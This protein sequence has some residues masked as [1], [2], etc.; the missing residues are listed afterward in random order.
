M[1]FHQNHRQ[2]QQPSSCPSGFFTPAANCTTTLT[3]QQQHLQSIYT[4]SEPPAMYPYACTGSNWNTSYSTFQQGTMAPQ[5]HATSP[6]FIGQGAYSNNHKA[7]NP[8]ANIQG[9]EIPQSEWKCDPCE[10]TFDSKRALDSHV[11]SHINCSICSFSAAPKVVK[12]HH[13]ATHGKFS[14]SGFKSITVAI[15]GCPIQQFRI[16]VGNHPDDIRAWIAERKRRFPRRNTVV[17][18]GN[19][20]TRP[21]F[22]PPPPQ[23]V[24]AST[25]P[26]MHPS[27]TTTETG[28]SSLLEGY[29]SS[30]SSDV[31]DEHEKL[32]PA[33]GCSTAADPPIQTNLTDPDK[34]KFS[35]D[36]NTTQPS[37][38]RNG[39]QGQ[40]LSR[41]CRFFLRNGS[42]RNG[43]HCNFLHERPTQ[44]STSDGQPSA[45]RLRKTNHNASLLERL[46]QN[47]MKR[48]A[49]LT[50]QLLDYIVETDFLTQDTPRPHLRIDD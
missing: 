30:S 46:L 28:L 8:I 21:H 27:R 29:G 2:Q 14:G 9:K 47:D 39:P 33:G 44:T 10:L 48:E 16:C 17:V 25:T 41:P 23:S 18:T 7:F 15:P 19:L 49:L 22:P 43:D 31:D 38:C 34:A 36:N 1:P 4:T 35:P 24:T 6:Y 12:A 50:L 26:K 13:Q 45:K 5:F 20:S 40:F 32:I 37:D 11:S 3:T 42:C